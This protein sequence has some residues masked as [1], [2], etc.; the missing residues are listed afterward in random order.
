MKTV[1]N[2]IAYIATGISVPSLIWV[3]GLNRHWWYRS[4]T[5][6]QVMLAILGS[7][8]YILFFIFHLYA[9]QLETFR[10]ERNYREQVYNDIK[11]LDEFKRRQNETDFEQDK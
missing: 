8:I 2:F 11:A 5:E 9:T 7:L 4:E 10:Q 1:I 3:E 6:V